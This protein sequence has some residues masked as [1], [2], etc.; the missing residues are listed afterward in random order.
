MDISKEKRRLQVSWH[1]STS[2]ATPHEMTIGKREATSSFESI[3]DFDWDVSFL[4]RRRTFQFQQTN[5]K[6][7]GE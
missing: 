4:R 6:T 3:E 2:V 1:R 5:F 7:P